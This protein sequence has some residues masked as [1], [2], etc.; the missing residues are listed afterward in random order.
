MQTAHPA[1]VHVQRTCRQN[2]LFESCC[3][4]RS[5]QRHLDEVV[6]NFEDGDDGEAHAEAQDA[7][8]VGHEPDDWNPLRWSSNGLLLSKETFDSTNLPLSVNVAVEIPRRRE[9]QSICKCLNPLL[10]PDL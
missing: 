7:A 8:A 9:E 4:E 5:L 2:R 6:E 1:P 3:S 10:F